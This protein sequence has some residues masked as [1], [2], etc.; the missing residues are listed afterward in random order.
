MRNGRGIPAD[1]LVDDFAVHPPADAAGSPLD[2][3]EVEVRS[4]V[5][6]EVDAEFVNARE[7]AVTRIL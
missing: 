3:V 7:T 5:E 1:P 6:P 4:R 2:R